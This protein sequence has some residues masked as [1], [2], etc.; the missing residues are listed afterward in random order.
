ALSGGAATV[1]VDSKSEAY[2]VAAQD[3]ANENV[4][5]STGNPL[6]ITIGGTG[7]VT[8]IPLPTGTIT[9]T[10][11]T[12]TGTTGTPTPTSSSG[13][14]PTPTI[15]NTTINLQLSLPGIGT[16]VGNTH[17]FHPLRPITFYL[18][19]IDTNNLITKQNSVVFDGTYFVRPVISL[20]EIPDGNYQVFIHSPQYL[21]TRLAQ[22]TGTNSIQIKN[23]Q[24]IQVTPNALIAG[25]IAPIHGATYGDNVL[26]ILDYNSLLSCYGRKSGSSACKDKAA[27]DL[28]DNGVIDAIDYNIMLRGFNQT[29]F[30]DTIP[31]NPNL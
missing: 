13:N 1:S 31:G 3:Q 28:D 14:T 22:T 7:T 8:P 5:S 6:S 17:P 19:N 15:I 18:Y 29:H 9:P 25:D 21:T 24:A 30:G 11:T 12:S 10:P 27:A 26:D 23:G 2:S 20:G 16:G 4:L